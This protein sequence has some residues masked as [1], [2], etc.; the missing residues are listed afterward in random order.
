[1]T[2]YPIN[3]KTACP[4]DLINTGIGFLDE[5]TER[6]ERCVGSS[7]VIAVYDTSKDRRTIVFLTSDGKLLRD[8][9]IV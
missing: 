3:I 8:S 7:L 4:G 5:G 9:W 2:L 6:L 1:M